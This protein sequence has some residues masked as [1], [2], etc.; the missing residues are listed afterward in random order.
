M[1]GTILSELG[2]EKFAA[3]WNCPCRCR[4]TVRT[5]CEAEQTEAEERGLEADEKSEEHVLAEIL[6]TDCPPML[7][8]LFKCLIAEEG[9][10]SEV[11]DLL[12]LLYAPLEEVM[13]WRH[14]LTPGQR[15]KYQQ[16]LRTHLNQLKNRLLLRK[17]PYCVVRPRKGYV[18]LQD[19]SLPT[20]TATHEFGVDARAARAQIEARFGS[21]LEATECPANL[22]KQASLEDCMNI[23][24][25]LLPPGCER[26]INEVKSHCNEHRC[27]PKTIRRA[28]KALN[29]NTR[30]MGFGGQS[31]VS[32]P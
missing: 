15:K 16:R 31:Y 4:P 24:R 2:D 29:A 14:D 3:W 11:W 27:R 21:I 6:G 26:E 13:L 32:L 18:A 9:R 17:Q 19:L 10:E 5:Q 25:D 1:T 23:L 20:R 8:K 30:R 12:E 22:P 7:V 28:L